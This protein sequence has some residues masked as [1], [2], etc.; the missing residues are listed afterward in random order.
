MTTFSE[1]GKYRWLQS[2]EDDEKKLN[3]SQCVLV[4][5]QNPICVRL[6]NGKIKKNVSNNLFSVSPVIDGDGIGDINQYNQH[7]FTYFLNAMHDIIQ[8]KVVAASH[9]LDIAQRLS[10]K[11]TAN[12]C[13]SGETELPQWF[14]IETDIPVLVAQFEWKNRYF[15]DKDTIKEFKLQVSHQLDGDNKDNNNWID[16]Q[17]FTSLQSAEWQSF[18]VSINKNTQRSRYWRFFVLSTYGG[19]TALDYL[20]FHLVDIIGSE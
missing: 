17:S 5:K 3:R 1:N 20:K 16:V 18:P 14:V 15:D 12:A 11:Q 19:F 6:Q 13:W 4:I 2:E 8:W 10:S 9:R 7:F